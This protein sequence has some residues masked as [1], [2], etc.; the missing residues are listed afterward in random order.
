MLRK[1]GEGTEEEVESVLEEYG[2]RWDWR[3]GCEGWRKGFDVGPGKVDV[4]EEEK[5][6]EAG[7]G[8]VEL[9]II[10]R[11]AIEQKVSVDLWFHKHQIN[12]QHYKV[13]LDIFVRK[14]LA[15][16]ALRQ[17]HVST[18]SSVR[19]LELLFRNLWYIGNGPLWA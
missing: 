6:A 19:S 13:V 11:E 5:G 2:E 12:K 10:T 16:R 15:T 17:P 18:R 8:G 3:T 7:D 9:I 14:A 1:C 4:E